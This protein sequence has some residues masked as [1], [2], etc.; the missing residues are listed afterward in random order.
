VEVHITNIYAREAF[1]H[2]SL[3]SGAA[4]AVICGC[5]VDGY[6]YAMQTVA[7]LINKGN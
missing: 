3:L 7:K 4:K 6:A 2:K 5:G 1:R